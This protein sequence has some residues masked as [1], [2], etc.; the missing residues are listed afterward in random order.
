MLVSIKAAGPLAHAL[1]A[2]G[3]HRVGVTAADRL[4]R[5]MHRLQTGAAHFVDGQRR[6]RK[7]QP[8]V[9]RG[10][11][12]RILPAAGG[13]HLAEDHFIDLLR[14]HAALRQQPLHRRRAQFHRR[15]RRQRAVKTADRRA[16]RRHDHHFTLL[17]IHLPFQK[18]IS[19][20]CS[21]TIS[22]PAV[23]ATIS[24]TLTP[25]ARS[26]STKAPSSISR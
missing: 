18:R 15:Q 4:H 20:T 9:Q 2:A 14:R 12:R 26:R 19:G 11:A 10:L 17:H 6:R 16:R 25:G 24:A 23:L 22:R 5:Q 21:G 7:R 8:G 3:D 1:L 13:Q